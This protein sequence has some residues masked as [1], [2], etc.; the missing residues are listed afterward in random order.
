MSSRKSYNPL[1]D[2]GLD[3]EGDFEPSGGAAKKWVVGVGLV[4]LPVLYG[5]YCLMT[6]RVV[7]LGSDSTAEGPAATGLA[8]SFVSVGLFIHAHWFWGLSRFAFIRPI[9]EGL[10]LVL[11]TCGLVFAMYKMLGPGM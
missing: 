6:S 11:F 4:L 1:T 9:L 10:S 3:V 7:L 8:I 5:V 2:E